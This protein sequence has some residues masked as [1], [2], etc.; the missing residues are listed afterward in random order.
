M[1]SYLLPVDG[2]LSPLWRMTY[3]EG[4]NCSLTSF[5]YEGLALYGFFLVCSP[6]TGIFLCGER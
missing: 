6:F 5:P 2:A 1:F 3:Y 4:V